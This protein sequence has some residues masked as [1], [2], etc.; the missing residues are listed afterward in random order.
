M[1]SESTAPWDKAEDYLQE[2]HKIMSCR[3]SAGAPG[4]TRKISKSH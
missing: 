4:D 3:E 2:K 1:G